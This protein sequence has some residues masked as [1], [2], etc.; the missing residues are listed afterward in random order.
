MCACR[1][2]DKNSTCLR[3]I[4]KIVMKCQSLNLSLLINSFL[5]APVL[6]S[7]VMLRKHASRAK[8][9]RVSIPAGM[10]A[11]LLLASGAIA[12]PPPENPN[13][14]VTAQIPVNARVVYVNPTLG[15]DGSSAGSESAPFRTISYAMQQAQ[16]N[17]VV[18]LAP[19]SY[20]RDT[21]EV[22]PIVVRPNV[23]LRGDESTKGQT[24]LII[25]SG[26]YA[27]PTFAVQNVTIRAESDSSVR[28][29]TVT[30][31]NSRGT[32]IWVESTNPSIRN[33]T[34]S[35]SLRDG[36]FV[37]G[38]AVPT[39]EGNIF[40][41]NQGNGVSV[42]RTARGE[43]RGNIFQNTGF[44]IA[45]GGDSAPRVEG[46]QVVQNVDG[47]VVSNN[48][49]PV[50][51]N[52]VIESN[53]R[54]GVV[55][56]ASAQPDLG[57]AESPGE[58]LIRNNGRY[59]LYNATSRNTI[60]AVGNQIDPEQIS[61]SVDFVAA[62][63][64]GASRFADVTGHWAAAYIEALADRNVIGG[65]PDGTY[66]PN[67]PVTRAQF[68][69][70]IN[71]AFSPTPER[72]GITFPDVRS[73]FWGNAAIQS[74]Y[75]GN[76]L[77]GYPDA[78]FQPNQ[79]IPRVQALVSLATGLKL[80][81]GDTTALT[82]YQDAAEIPAYATGAIAAATQQGIIVNYP[83]VQ[84]LNPN[85]VA[86]RAD[87]AAFI[88]QALVNAGQAEAIPSPYLVLSSDINPLQ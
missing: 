13:S 81:T 10:V 60:L 61:G 4:N 22:F 85:Q 55:A 45:I 53:T 27:S 87:V 35:N 73:D 79:Q 43:I 26:T 14:N 82:R 33:S 63:V 52:N 3:S 62:T 9:A 32:G 24:V 70:I 30:N 64:A 72:P 11:L 68:A 15:T 75:R 56:I 66:R 47:I 7:K 17:T 21:G 48:A 76:F 42:A 65:F 8:S 25:G 23:I 59:D 18:Q 44:G 40:T 49:R 54:D 36:I 28:G 83:N 39:I 51:R 57:N 34:L 77:S 1:S 37:T 38:T 58:N 16:P 88:Y 5:C 84:Q 20:T 74:A 78:T 41:G 69:A 29:V 12:A 67:E 50:L 2:L 80:S 19:G 31:P 6:L 71:A 86:T 46:N